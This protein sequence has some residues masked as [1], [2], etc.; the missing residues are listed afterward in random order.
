[1][2]RHI[3]HGRPQMPLGRYP[4]CIPHEDI[5]QVQLGRL[6]EPCGP[7]SGK[8]KSFK[9]RLGDDEMTPSTTGTPWAVPDSH[10]TAAANDNELGIYPIRETRGHHTCSGPPCQ[11]FTALDRRLGGQPAPSDNPGGQVD[12]TR[13][14]QGQFPPTIPDAVP[15]LNSKSTT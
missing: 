12:G 13:Q 6:P 4:H 7:A 3:N 9:T 14:R 5:C 11:T 15:I 1:M 2:A 8:S 10:G